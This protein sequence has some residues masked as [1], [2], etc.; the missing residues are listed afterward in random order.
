MVL[1]CVY[2]PVWFVWEGGCDVLLT[3]ST[4]HRYNN[5]MGRRLHHPPREGAA[6]SSRTRASFKVNFHNTHHEA[7]S[8]PVPQVDAY[9]RCLINCR[10]GLKIRLGCAREING[11][12]RE[13]GLKLS[14]E[15]VGSVVETGR[16][17]DPSKERYSQ[18]DGYNEVIRIMTWA[19]D[20]NVY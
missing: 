18:T 2:T 14:V 17:G 20:R 13:G 11:C 15:V 7:K 3:I 6:V 16:T 9:I 19:C 5:S 4:L 1:S 8:G 10:T 12:R